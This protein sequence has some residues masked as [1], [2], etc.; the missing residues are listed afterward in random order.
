MRAPA[1]IGALGP[2]GGMTLGLV[3]FLPKRRAARQGG[4]EVKQRTAARDK[5]GAAPPLNSGDWKHRD[6][7]IFF[8]FTICSGQRMAKGASLNLFAKKLVRTRSLW[9]EVSFVVSAVAH[10]ALCDH[11]GAVFSYLWVRLRER[12]QIKPVKFTWALIHR[13]AYLLD[14][15]GFADDP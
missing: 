7:F 12:Q 1:G 3:I 15:S 6:V 4:P 2:P 14:D 5:G 10:A 13:A 9:L 8:L 11:A